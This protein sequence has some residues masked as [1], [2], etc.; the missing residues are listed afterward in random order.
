MLLRRCFLNKKGV[1]IQAELA[2]IVDVYCSIWNEPTAA[3]R[4]ELFSTVLAISC[5][6]CDPTVDVVGYES[7]DKHIESVRAKK[8]GIVFRTTDVDIHHDVARFGWRKVL[9]NGLLLP[10]GVDF[11]TI[12][13]VGKISQISGF[14]GPLH[15]L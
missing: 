11:L 1:M 12:D 3:R 13:S 10:E 7:L 9:L 15:S 5:R 14:F 4:L 2:E 6:Y 8:P